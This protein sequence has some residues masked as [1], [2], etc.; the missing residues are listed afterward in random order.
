MINLGRVS[1]ERRNLAIKTP[2]KEAIVVHSNPQVLADLKS[3]E[4]YVLQELNVRLFTATSDE[5]AF[6][7][8]LRAD[9]NLP[10]LGKRLG[11]DMK[12]VTSEVRNMT[13][14][15]IRKFQADGF[16]QFGAHKLSS[17][18][19]IVK[20]EF[21]NQSETME[22]NSDGDLVVI[23]DCVNET[24]LVLEGLARELINRIQKLRKK[25]ERNPP[26]KK[27]SSKEKN[28]FSFLFFFFF[29]AYLGW[30][31]SHR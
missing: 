20:K 13:A 11:K 18:D 27:I 1:R 17:E 14:E 30:P 4:P 8:H 3:I 5:G 21:K 16:A 12:Q 10:V 7:M 9:P 25:V 24:H 15:A 26:R 31:Q 6:G 22:A 2:L 29:W 19:I 28:F 23:L